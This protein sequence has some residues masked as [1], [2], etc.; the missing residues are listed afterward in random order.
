[1]GIRSGDASRHG[2]RGRGARRYSVP[3]GAARF[4]MR[5]EGRQH[6]IF[7]ADDTLWENNIY[8]EKAFDEFCD[9]LSHSH[10]SAE[11]VRAHLDEIEIANAKVYGYGARNFARNLRACYAKL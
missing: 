9:F 11:E 5:I 8:F 7:D 6:L 1:M 10:L 2:G 4:A 3:P